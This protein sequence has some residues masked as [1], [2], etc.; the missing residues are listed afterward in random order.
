MST[1]VVVL[2]TP[3]SGE[4]EA[5]AAYGAGVQPLLAA[6]GAK[7]GFRGPVTSTVAGSNSPASFLALEFADAAAVRGFFGSEDYLRLLPTREKA[8]ERMEIFV[9][10]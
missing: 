2:A 4:A 8:F 9:I 7:I 3:R 10:G 5:L 6:A 1:H